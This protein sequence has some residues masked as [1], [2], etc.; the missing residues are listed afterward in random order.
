[1]H[2]K[3]NKILIHACCAIC[4]GHPLDVLRELGFEPV[5]YFFNPN[6]HPAAEYEKRLE[7]QKTLCSNLNCELIIENYAPQVYFEAVKGFENCPEGA[8]RCSKC[9]E[10]RLG[11]TAQKAKELG[12][13]NFTTT[14]SISPHKNFETIKKIGQNLSER[15]EINFIDIN[16][17]KQDGFLKTNKIARDLNLYRQ[18]YCGCKFSIRGET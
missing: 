18:N 7:A 3:E 9:F 2:L 11:K 4:S 5:V 12:F 8:E 15:Y 17:K 14:I 6:I 1:M 16:F 13:E 10:L